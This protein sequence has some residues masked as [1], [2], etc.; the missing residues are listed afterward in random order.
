MDEGR[1]FLNGPNGALV[2]D[3]ELSLSPP[4]LITSHTSP[5]AHYLHYEHEPVR[6]ILQ[7]IKFNSYIDR[8]ICLNIYFTLQFAVPHVSIDEEIL[9]FGY[10]PPNTQSIESKVCCSF[11][12]HCNVTHCVQYYA[13]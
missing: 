12:I 6:I 5:Y 8:I 11:Y 10:C 3:A 7:W 13:L 4:S 9:K 2:P 1:V